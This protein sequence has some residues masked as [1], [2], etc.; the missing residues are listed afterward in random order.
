MDKEFF[1]CSKG[2]RFYYVKTD[3]EI[4][5][6]READIKTGNVMDSAGE[7]ILYSRI[8]RSVFREDTAVSI[9]KRRGIEWPHWTPKPTHLVEGLATIGG[10]PRIIMFKIR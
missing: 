6:Q 1:V 2:S 10:V 8:A 4:D 9:T 5:A 7:S 3:V